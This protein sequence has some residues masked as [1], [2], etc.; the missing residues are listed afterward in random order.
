MADL[1]VVF[2]Q[3]SFAFD[4]H[5]VLRN[6]SFEIAK[7]SMKILLGA[8][9]SGKSTILKLLLGLI[10]PDSGTIAVNG[11]RV[12]SMSERDLMHVRADIGMLFQENALFDSLTVAGNVGYRL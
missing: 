3:V 10:R 2:D 11:L 5:V 4:D 7:G 1:A 9:G 12:D 8:S 6:V